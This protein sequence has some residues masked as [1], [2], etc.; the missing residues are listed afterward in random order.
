MDFS[1][2]IV[3]LPLDF[4]SSLPWWP[5]GN[6]YHFFHELPGNMPIF[7]LFFVVS[8]GFSAVAY[9][10]ETLET[11]F[12]SFNIL[13]MKNVGVATFVCY[14]QTLHAIE[15]I[16]NESKE[17]LMRCLMSAYDKRTWV[18]TTWI[19]V[20]F[21]RVSIFVVVVAFTFSVHLF[22]R[23]NVLVVS[24][25][26]CLRLWVRSLFPQAVLA[27]NLIRFQIL[28]ETK[29]TKYLAKILVR[30]LFYLINA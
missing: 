19:L 24:Y 9:E 27:E 8:L 14:P 6:S 5:C 11:F 3:P 17:Q 23:N 16:K 22:K 28:S 13:T 20:R 10:I 29:R 12:F 30:R 15:T 26:A 7:P 25:P 18:H 1:G 4:Q 21:W 2:K